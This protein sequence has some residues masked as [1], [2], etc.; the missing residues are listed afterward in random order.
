MLE[1]LAQFSQSSRSWKRSST[2]APFDAEA[3]MAEVKARLAQ[4]EKLLQQRM[5]GSERR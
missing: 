5:G 2:P 1:D 3:E 4:L